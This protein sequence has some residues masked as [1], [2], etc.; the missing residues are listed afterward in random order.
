MLVNESSY[1]LKAVC[2]VIKVLVLTLFQS[3]YNFVKV[4]VCK[5]H[6]ICAVGHRK[7]IV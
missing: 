4:A 7:R 5:E 6:R 3:L 2:C 1:D